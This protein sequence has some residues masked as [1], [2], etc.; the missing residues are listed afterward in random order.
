MENDGRPSC[1]QV[2]TVL[3]GN[4]SLRLLGLVQ[5]ASDTATAL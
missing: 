2:Q 4:R 3:S 1:R 5:V